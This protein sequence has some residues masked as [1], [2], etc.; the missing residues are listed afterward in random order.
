MV[1]EKIRSLKEG[2][3]FIPFSSVSNPSIFTLGWLEAPKQI[4]LKKS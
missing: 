2:L 3:D 1:D 4:L